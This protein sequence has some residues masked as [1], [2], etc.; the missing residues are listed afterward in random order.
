MTLEKCVA[1]INRNIGVLRDLKN[2]PTVRVAYK[3]EDGW[4][5][6]RVPKQPA[7]SLRSGAV[8]LVEDRLDVLLTE[9]VGL[10]IDAAL[11]ELFSGLNGE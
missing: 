9:S 3:T 2:S 11:A 4:K 8:E 6:L 7:K 5:R 10:A 1:E